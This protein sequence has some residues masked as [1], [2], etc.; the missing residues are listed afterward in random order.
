MSFLFISHSSV[1]RE[2]ALDIKE[3]LAAEGYEGLFLDLDPVNGVPVGRSWEQELYSQLRRCGAIILLA[4]RASV[5][6]EWCFAEVCLAR[7]LDRPVFQLSL[8][9]ESRFALLAAEQAINLLK[10]EAAYSRLWRGLK[11]AGLDP[12]DSISFPLN[13]EV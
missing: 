11:S 3:P 13:R 4:S 7:S 2:A 12:A 8:D 5:Q 10:G 1:D 6:S 9:G